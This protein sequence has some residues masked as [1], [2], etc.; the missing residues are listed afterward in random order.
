[1][2]ALARGFRAA[3]VVFLPFRIARC[4][5][6]ASE[7][8]NFAGGLP[9]I[10]ELVNTLSPTISFFFTI[11]AKLCES[12]APVTLE[13]N[14]TSDRA[15]ASRFFYAAS[16]LACVPGSQAQ[17]VGRAL[18]AQ[19]GPRRLTAVLHEAGF[20]RVRVAARTAMNLVVEAR[21]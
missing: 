4:A 10:R 15:P 6:D 1:M 13:D 7:W 12:S 20:N 11:A 2:R 5:S 17:E 3:F 14:L 9:M 21:A 16:T 8:L 19:A 18:G